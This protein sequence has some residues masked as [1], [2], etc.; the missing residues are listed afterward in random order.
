MTKKEKTEAEEIIDRRKA[1]IDELR[2][3]PRDILE[4][5]KKA[6]EDKIRDRY[7]YF[8]VEGGEFPTNQKLQDRIKNLT[9]A[10]K[11]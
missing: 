11:P 4:L 10:L 5:A 2:K 9:E 1:V 7:I 6:I 8:C 3:I